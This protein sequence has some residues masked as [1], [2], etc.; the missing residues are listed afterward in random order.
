MF[1]LDK[2]IKFCTM[3]STLISQSMTLQWNET[4]RSCMDQSNRGCAASFRDATYWKKGSTA[5]N[6]RVN[7]GVEPGLVN[8]EGRTQLR[9]QGRGSD[10]NF[11]KM[12]SS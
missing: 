2:K 6:R 7:P 4:V 8:R 9:S 5:Q 1:V 10:F 11:E 3:F 12:S